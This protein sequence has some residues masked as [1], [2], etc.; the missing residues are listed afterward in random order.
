MVV[1]TSTNVGSGYGVMTGGMAVSWEGEKGG[2]G[3]GRGK[4]EYSAI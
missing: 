1:T 3:E 2:N 4:L